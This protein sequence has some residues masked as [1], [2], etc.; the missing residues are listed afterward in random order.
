MSEEKLLRPIRNL[1]PILSRATLLIE[2]RNR[3][4]RHSERFKML[5]RN[6]KKP[7]DQLARISE[8]FDAVDSLIRQE[9]PTLHNLVIK[10]IIRLVEKLTAAQMQSFSN[11]RTIFQRITGKADVPEWADINADFE[12]EFRSTHVEQKIKGLEIIPSLKSRSTNFPNE[13]M[14]MVFRPE[15][16]ADRHSRL[17]ARSG[18]FEESALWSSKTSN[19]CPQIS[20]SAVSED[21]DDSVPSNP[22]NHKL[23]SALSLHKFYAGTTDREAGY[24]YLCYDVGEVC[25]TRCRVL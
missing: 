25:H 22:K 6:G 19:V 16:P 1:A 11:W 2:H 14:P 24:P 5:E 8:E 20:P 13:G 21:K 9:L 12:R 10:L 18:N 7:D 15:K 3:R 23:W 4:L 17:F